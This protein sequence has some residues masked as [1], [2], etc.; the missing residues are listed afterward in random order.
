MSRTPEDDPKA[1]GPIVEQVFHQARQGPVLTLNRLRQ[2]WAGIVGEPLARATWPT[3]LARGVLWVAAPDSG[4]AFNL[5]FVKADLLN[6]VRTFL[7]SEAVT[8]IRFKVGE[9]P[10]PEERA[11]AGAAPG[12]DEEVPETVGER[13]AAL[14]G[15]AD[16]LKAPPPPAA[17][18]ETPGAEPGPPAVPTPR[19]DAPA[20]ADPPASGDAPEGD[21]ALGRIADPRLRGLFRR[22][23]DRLRR[24]PGGDS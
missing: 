15:L 17:G 19:A 16:R 5:Q 21:E 14:R 8:E 6:G 11:A 10:T 12:G 13:S 7:G 18:D 23:G 9:L 20:A 3:R 22:L 2:H 1:V 4:W 24:G